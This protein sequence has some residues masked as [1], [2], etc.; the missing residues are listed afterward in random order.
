MLKLHHIYMEEKRA[1][2]AKQKASS[3]KATALIR[4]VHNV[5]K[6]N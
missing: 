3:I 6:D 2:T 4:N 5:Y 1:L